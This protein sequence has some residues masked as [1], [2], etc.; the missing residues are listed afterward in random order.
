MA[1]TP[2]AGKDA[3]ILL[4]AV[5]LSTYL[6]D[7]TVTHTVN[8]EDVSVFGDADVRRTPTLRDISA[9]LSGIGIGSTDDADDI[10]NERLASS[11]DP[12]ATVGP[13]GDSTG[14]RAD[15]FSGIVTNFEYSAPVA[16]VVSVSA[17]FEN[18]KEQGGG[19]WLRPLS[20]NDGST[21]TVSG[22][23][24]VSASTGGTTGG[25]VAHLHA[26][27]VA[28]NFDMAVKIQHTSA[29]G[30]GWTDVATFTLTTASSQH[31]QRLTA[32][33]A[34]KENVRFQGDPN[35]TTTGDGATFALAFAR[36]GDVQFAD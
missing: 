36:L 26:T 28:S 29:T 32:T 27:T 33:G 30:S 8:T 3:V 19:R 15:L 14:N 12:I 2:V 31:A 34:V 13:A 17:D 24:V 18:A 4:D 6:N 1:V 25:L 10:F 11:T 16:G 22:G 9:S 35:G 20:A 7:Y 21:S 23:K 5:S